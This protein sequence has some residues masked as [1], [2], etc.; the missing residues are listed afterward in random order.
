M[1][2]ALGLELA[3]IASGPLLIVLIVWRVLRVLHGFMSTIEMQQH[4]ESKKVIAIPKYEG[5]NH[6][7]S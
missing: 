7:D 5:I 1:G 2:F 6:K 4:R 3:G